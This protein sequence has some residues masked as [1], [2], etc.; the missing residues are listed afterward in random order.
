MDNAMI[1]FRKPY[2]KL[3]DAEGKLVESAQLIFVSL[4]SPEELVAAPEFLAYETEGH[5]ASL[6]DCE[7]YIL[8]L[9]KKPDGT[10][11]TTV[12]PRYAN[13]KALAFRKKWRTYEQY[14]KEKIGQFFQIKLERQTE[15]VCHD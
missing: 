7:Y 14:Y 3:K 13:N 8:L 5:R 15:E 2:N 6:D 9:F 1:F 11:F 4:V 12:R 10:L